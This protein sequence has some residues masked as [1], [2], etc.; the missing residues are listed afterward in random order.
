MNCP[1]VNRRGSEIEPEKLSQ[2]IPGDLPVYIKRV[3]ALNS[4]HGGREEEAPTAWPMEGARPT[5][6]NAAEDR[7]KSR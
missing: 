5:Y 2:Q 7:H 4:P 3:K 1:V 6:S